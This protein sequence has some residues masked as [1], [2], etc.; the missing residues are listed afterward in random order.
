MDSAAERGGNCDATEAGERKVGGHGQGPLNLPSTA[1][2]RERHGAEYRNLP[3][4]QKD[5]R[6]I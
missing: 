3:R 5:V 4:Y 1:V 2:S 6:S